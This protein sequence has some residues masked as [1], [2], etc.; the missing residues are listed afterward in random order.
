MKGVQDLPALNLL[1]ADFIKEVAKN[2]A[3]LARFNL[4]V[5]VEGLND[6]M[7][8]LGGRTLMGFALREKLDGLAGVLIQ[9]N[10][11]V[12]QAI[13]GKTV[14]QYALEN[15]LFKTFLALAAKGTDVNT[16]TAT[17]KTA[18]HL[19]C[20]Q[21]KLDLV[22][23]LAAKGANFFL[24]D[25]A[26]KTPIF[27]L[28]ANKQYAQVFQVLNGLTVNITPEQRDALEAALQDDAIAAALQPMDA[29]RFK[30]INTLVNLKVDVPQELL[31]AALEYQMFGQSE[32][33]FL[34]TSFDRLLKAGA[35][36]NF[37]RVMSSV[38]NKARFASFVDSIG[39]E[40]MLHSVLNRAIVYAGRVLVQAE[41]KITGVAVTFDAEKATY[42]Q[43]T[44][45][46]MDLLAIVSAIIVN[47]DDDLQLDEHDLTALFTSLQE[48]IDELQMN[49]DEIVYTKEFE[50]VLAALNL[51]N[52]A[53]LEAL[54]P[55][56]D[57]FVD[58]YSAIFADA[59]RKSAQELNQIKAEF[60]AE[61]E[62]LLKKVKRFDAF[63]K[64]L[65]VQREQ[66]AVLPL[67]YGG[68]IQDREDAETRVEQQTSD[69]QKW[70]M[71]QRIDTP[72][73]LADIF[74][75]PAQAFEALGLGDLF[76]IPVIER[77]E[78]RYYME[79][80]LRGLKV[81]SDLET[82]GIDGTFSNLVDTSKSRLG[83]K[84]Q[85]LQEKMEARAKT[86]RKTAYSA[87]RNQLFEEY[88]TLRTAYVSIRATY[89]HRLQ[90]T[91]WY[92]HWKQEAENIFGKLS[93]IK[94]KVSAQKRLEYSSD[95]A[96]FLTTKRAEFEV[97]VELLR[98]HNR[99]LQQLVL[100]EYLSQPNLQQY[101]QN[102]DH[103]VRQAAEDSDMAQ[104]E[105]DRSISTLEN[106]DE[107]NF[108]PFALT[109]G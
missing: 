101:W 61:K 22:A 24:K 44:K 89:N 92:T 76:G 73:L 67:T 52:F 69:F 64:F 35:V 41:A 80:A 83:Q 53:P 18:L 95:N 107:E 17:G 56:V 29:T 58:K 11:R 12:P 86:P 23:E 57:V 1:T 71:H 94:G 98:E 87:Y 63:V 32:P 84:A 93:S 48:S 105:S 37:E 5:P 102:V 99:K 109:V 54:Y 42:M 91:P 96:Q 38:E 28:L 30:L 26:G 104:L 14:A 40:L 33:P 55:H 16:T 90:G 2:P 59:T 34:A 70:I 50:A 39:S 49:R 100:K 4:Q 27:H 10:A 108:N 88:N 82:L 45:P 60:A 9:K 36:P 75:D 97:Q 3:A 47:K 85:T 51:H 13:D 21:N 8:K 19:A 81:E 31:N 79:M 62:A 78:D 103:D 7:P 43:D 74:D 106:V 77:Q 66:P 72:E 65:E 20:E 46:A 25:A 6:V 15:N 68:A